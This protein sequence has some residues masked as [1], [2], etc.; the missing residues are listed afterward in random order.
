MNDDPHI[1]EMGC[2]PQGR[3]VFISDGTTAVG[4]ALIA[5]FLAAG[6]RHLWVGRA[7]DTTIGDLRS[8]PGT[9]SIVP[10][11]VRNSDSV[12]GAVQAIGTTVDIVVNNSRYQGGTAQAH[13]EMEFNYFGLLNLTQHFETRVS[14]AWVNLLTLDALCSL[15]SQ[16]TFSASMAAAHS[17][18]Q[19]LRAR[20]RP[21]GVRVVNVF[22]GPVGVDSLS[23]SV[24]AGLRD[25][26]EDVFPGDMAQDW[27]A[28]WLDS[29]KVLEREVA[30]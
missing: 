1:R 4:Q 17:L 23:R 11:D 14:A 29:P 10:L 19:A 22:A 8:G 30:R 16:A 13:A 7:P 28:R 2:D 9:V 24:V 21:S 6:A 18:S 12:R 27:L 3:D 25:G 15:P 5:E 26:V 20:L